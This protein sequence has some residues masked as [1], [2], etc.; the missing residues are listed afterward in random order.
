MKHSAIFTLLSLVALFGCVRMQQS[1]Y[2]RYELPKDLDHD[3]QVK[4]AMDVFRTMQSQPFAEEVR[5]K[6]PDVTQAQLMKTDLRWDVVTTTAPSR[7]F[8]ISFGVKDTRDFPQAEAIVDFFLE[9]G[10]RE[11]EK[12][13][14]HAYERKKKAEP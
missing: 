8:F 13:I 6:F 9:F 7:A 12:L 10:K 11:A 5:R 3:T 1:I 14:Q 4:I 2:K